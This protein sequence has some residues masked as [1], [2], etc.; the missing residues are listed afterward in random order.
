MA[1]MKALF[2]H[3][4]TRDVTS[5]NAD[6]S[7]WD[8]SK[9]TTMYEMFKGATSFNADISKWDVSRVT[10]MRRMFYAASSFSQKLSGAWSTSR[11]DKHAMFTGTKG[12]YIVGY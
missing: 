12:A 7:R 4:S 10:D 8:V 3:S 9:V 11:A 6:I 1:N 2:A 5:F